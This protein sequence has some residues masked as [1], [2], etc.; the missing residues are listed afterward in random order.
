MAHSLNL[1]ALEQYFRAAAA[2][3]AA[4]HSVKCESAAA[5]NLNVREP[6]RRAAGAVESAPI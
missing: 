1:T 2:M 6:R 4:F 5:I 3:V